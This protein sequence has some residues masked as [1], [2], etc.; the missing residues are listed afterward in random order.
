MHP[1]G[2]NVQFLFRGIDSTSTLFSFIDINGV[3]KLTETLVS[4]IQYNSTAP[5]A[6]AYKMIIQLSTLL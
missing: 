4:I 1:K 3:D 6:T 2:Y 5:H